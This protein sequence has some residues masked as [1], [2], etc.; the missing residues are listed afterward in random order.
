M[1]SGLFTQFAAACGNPS[2]FGLPTW[3]KYL[4]KGT[5]ALGNCK[6][7]VAHLNDYWLIGLGVIDILLRLVGLISV[8]FVIYG[9]IKYVLSQGEPE[10]TTKALHTVINA[11]VGVGIAV[12][13]SA[14]VAFVANRLT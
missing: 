1:F 6:V 2:F 14:L 4:H 9:G 7:T 11:L 3:Y 13:A 8:G 5:D 12:I 10:N